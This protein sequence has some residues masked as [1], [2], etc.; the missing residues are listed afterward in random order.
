MR[1]ILSSMLMVMISARSVPLDPSNSP[2]SGLLLRRQSACERAY[3]LVNLREDLLHPSAMGL[4]Q[5]LPQ[6]S[7]LSIFDRMA[8]VI[9]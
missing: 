8:E 7:H 6:L 1:K 9:A 3:P 4:R 5:H 2:G